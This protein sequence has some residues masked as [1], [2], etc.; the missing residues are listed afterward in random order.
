MPVNRT[1]R[2]R[3]ASVSSRPTKARSTATSA[4]TRRPSSKT[5]ACASIGSCLPTASPVRRRHRPWGSPHGGVISA[6]AT[7]TR[8]ALT[9]DCGGGSQQILPPASPS[10]HR[11]TISLLRACNRP[12]R[13]DDP[14]GSGD[15]VDRGPVWTLHEMKATDGVPRLDRLPENGQGLEEP[16][17]GRQKVVVAIERLENGRRRQ[18]QGGAR[19][20]LARQH[21]G[22]P[23]EVPEA[24]RGQPV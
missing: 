23:E 18:A 11:Y 17:L 15:E 20:S 8:S 13:A 24:A 4:A 6:C 19:F 3:T 22:V 7:P 1:T 5:I 16:A 10:D 21:P 14:G 9:G 2:S 12:N